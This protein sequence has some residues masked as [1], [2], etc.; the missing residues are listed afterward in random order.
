MRNWHVEVYMINEADGSLMPANVFEKVTY[1]LHESFGKRATQG[2]GNTSAP[3]LHKPTHT[4]TNNPVFQVERQRD[5]EI[6]I[7]DTHHSSDENCTLP[8]PRRRLG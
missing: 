3:H 4:R 6:R 2:K 5:L 8:L 7:A 1:K